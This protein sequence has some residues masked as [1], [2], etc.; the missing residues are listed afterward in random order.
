[1]G[2]R[3][4]QLPVNVKAEILAAFQGGALWVAGSACARAVLVGGGRGEVEVAARGRAGSIGTNRHSAG[5]PEPTLWSHT[6]SLLS[7][8]PTILE[9]AVRSG[10]T[11]LI[12]DLLLSN[13]EQQRLLASASELA[14]ALDY[15]GRPSCWPALPA[16]PAC[17]VSWW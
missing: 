4:E 7:V 3:P 10:C 11:H 1:M 6:C 8:A 16:P 5:L 15:L 17:V 2:V 14:A 12:I 13:E 9:G